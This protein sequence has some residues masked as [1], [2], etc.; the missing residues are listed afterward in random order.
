MLISTRSVHSRANARDA[1]GV[2]AVGSVLGWLKQ[3][4]DGIGTEVVSEQMTAD[5]EVVGI[6]APLVSA[7]RSRAGR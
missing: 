2:I 7:A 5:V 6:E 3:L 1:F 4:G